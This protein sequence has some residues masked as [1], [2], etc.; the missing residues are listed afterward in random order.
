MS[1]AEKEK[2]YVLSMG[3]ITALGEDVPGC[4]VRL[5]EGD[6]PLGVP[7]H[8]KT[9][10]AGQFPLGEVPFSNEELSAMLGLRVI[11]PRTALLSLKAAREAWS[12]VGEKSEGLRKAFWSANT[13]GGMDLTESWF[14]DR[15]KLDVGPE[16]ISW[17][18]HHEGGAVT[19]L[20][21]DRLGFDFHTTL[22]TACSSSANSLMM[23]ARQ[24]AHGHRDIALAGGADCLTRFTLNGFCSLKILDQGI[25]RPFDAHRQGLNLG[26][27]AAYLV[28]GNARAVDQLGIQP[29]ACLKGYGNANDA[30]HQTASSPE[31]KGN[32]A[33]MRAALD[34]AGLSPED[35]G[36][37][38][39]HGTGTANNDESEGMAVE[40]I[41]GDRV[42]PASSTK[43]N[44]GHTLG[45]AGAVEACFCLWTLSD[46]WV[47]PNRN[48][49]HPMTELSWQPRTEKEVDPG[50]RHVLSNSFGFG[51]N[52]TSLIFSNPTDG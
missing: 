49:Q 20:V 48:L 42:P 18:I 16:G 23:A 52:C 19:S 21:A 25:C 30:Y 15:G 11:W 27:G 22:S 26:E 7:R 36:Y 45:A 34:E 17:M 29:L 50:I 41:F 31:G 1:V 51:G 43:P 40:A 33:A 2:V 44:T 4:R 6:S 47:Y 39:L 14:F 37:I 5:W 38:N 24:I 46:G 10:L 35:I 9:R 28:L 8:L 13:V 12:P 3:M 32:Q